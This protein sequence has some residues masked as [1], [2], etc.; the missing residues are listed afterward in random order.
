MMTLCLGSRLALPHIRFE[1]ATCGHRFF[2]Y[3]GKNPC[4]RKYPATCRRGPRFI[5]YVNLEEITLAYVFTYS[6]Y[7]QIVWLQIAIR[8]VHIRDRTCT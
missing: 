6:V 8:P 1:N 5:Q 4:F 2:K 7:V 3:G